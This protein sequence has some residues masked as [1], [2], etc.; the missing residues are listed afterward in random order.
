MRS[1]LLQTHSDR[2]ELRVVERTD[3][4]AVFGNSLTKNGRSRE[5]PR[6]PKKESISVID[7]LR[8]SVTERAQLQGPVTQNTPVVR[9]FA[10][11]PR[12][13]IIPRI[14][15]GVAGSRF[16][17]RTIHSQLIE[18]LSRFIIE[19]FRPT[20]ESKPLTVEEERLSTV[21]VT[22]LSMA[23]RPNSAPSRRDR[24]TTGME[25]KTRLIRKCIVAPEGPIQ[26]ELGIA[27]LSDPIP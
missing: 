23:V 16:S 18:E 27:R 25:V 21:H 4:Q 19:N 5:H 11:D 10:L 15:H 6:S 2:E 1:V 3:N 24:L 12:Q 17:E 13:G 14:D 22:V 9:T 7:R 26:S 20:D 8:R